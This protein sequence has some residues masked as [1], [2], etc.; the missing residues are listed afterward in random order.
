MVE[1]GRVHLANRLA[2]WAVSLYFASFYFLILDRL[3]LVWDAMRRV[4]PIVDTAYNLAQMSA[5]AIVLTVIVT[6]LVVEAAQGRMARGP[7]NKLRHLGA[8]IGLPL[9]MVVPALVHDWVLHG[10]PWDQLLFLVMLGGFLAIPVNLGFVVGNPSAGEL[11]TQLGRIGSVVVGLAMTVS[12]TAFL[13]V[14]TTTSVAA[15][16]GSWTIPMV[17][18]FLV[19]AIPT[20][21]A[22]GAVVLGRG[23]T[24]ADVGA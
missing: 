13:A 11:A 12:L 18:A 10:M 17:M 20:A 22:A 2:F 1:L 16:G 4:N 3:D 9:M 15:P 6:A 5:G 14:Q 21:A 24:A 19:I 7:W 8:G 23:P